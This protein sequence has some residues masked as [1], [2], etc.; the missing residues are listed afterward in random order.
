MDGTVVYIVE[1]AVSDGRRESVGSVPLGVFDDMDEAE[2][3][4]STGHHRVVEVRKGVCDPVGTPP[5]IWYPKREEY[6]AARERHDDIVASIQDYQVATMPQPP[7][8][9]SVPS[10]D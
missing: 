7:P 3:Q 2:E 4:C 9:A 5:F 6:A 1:M 10:N 8:V